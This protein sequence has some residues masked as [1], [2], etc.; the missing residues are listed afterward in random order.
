M[1]IRTTRVKRTP[2]GYAPR[3]DVST[4]S[5]GRWLSIETGYLCSFAVVKNVAIRGLLVPVS[6]RRERVVTRSQP[7]R[8][9]PIMSWYIADLGW[10]SRLTREA[11]LNYVAQRMA[12]IF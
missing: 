11:W 6:V 4:L 10:S 1:R 9:R 5:I 2:I 12:P 8:G 7:Q 3:A